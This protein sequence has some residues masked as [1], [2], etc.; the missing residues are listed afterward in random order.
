VLTTHNIQ[1]TSVKGQRHHEMKGIT[2][3]QQRAIECVQAE[4][5]PSERQ[6]QH[7]PSFFLQKKESMNNNKEPV[8]AGPCRKC[9]SCLV[10]VRGHCVLIRMNPNLSLWGS[11]RYY[12]MSSKNEVLEQSGILMF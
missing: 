6:G 10:G 4:P 5:R 12:L 9:Q 11:T 3:E 7:V 1:D 2:Q 8:K